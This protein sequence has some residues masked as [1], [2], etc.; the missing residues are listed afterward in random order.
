MIRSFA[1]TAAAI[2]LRIYLPL[3]PLTG[4]SFSTSYRIIAWACW[5]P[6]L[7]VAEWILRYQRSSEPEPSTYT[8]SYQ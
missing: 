7:F 4:L 8:V 3:L 6:N 5:V 2:T 1:L